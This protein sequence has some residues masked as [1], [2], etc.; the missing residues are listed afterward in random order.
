MYNENMYK[1]KHS[2]LRLEGSRDVSERRGPGVWSSRGE[3]EPFICAF[4]LDRKQG[5]QKAALLRGRPS[6][7]RVNIYEINVG[8]NAARL[9]TRC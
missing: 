4:L 5:G 8:K 3:S 9:R 2:K 7:P 6:G 1:E